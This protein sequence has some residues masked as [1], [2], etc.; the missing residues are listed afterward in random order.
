MKYSTL[1][2]CLVVWCFSACAS[3]AVSIPEELSPL[4]IIQRAQEASD[5][6]RYHIA[7][8]YYETLLERNPDNLELIPEEKALENKTMHCLARYEIAFIHYKQKKHAQ[9]KMEFESLLER[10]TAPD[11][12][13]LPPKFKLL[14]EKV[15][16][17]INEKNKK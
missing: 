9:A 2:I 5:R 13:T 16:D 11:R 12:G 7:L 1:F 17:R 14:S 8:Q 6:S 4:E 15:L 10:Y 3:S